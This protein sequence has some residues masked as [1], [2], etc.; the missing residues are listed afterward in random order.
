MKKIS[1]I[2]LALAVSAGVF[3][4]TDSSTGSSSGINMV[5]KRGVNILPEEGEFALG[6]NATPFLAYIGGFFSNAGGGAPSTNYA[7][8]IGGGNAI[9][10]KYMIAPDAAI[11]ANFQLNT[12]SSSLLFNVPTSNLTPNPLQPA[13][14]QDKLVTHS[15]GILLGIGYEKHRGKGRVNGYYGGQVLFGK[16]GFSSE[17]TYGN[18]I[19]ANFNTPQ[20]HNAYVS[21]NQRILKDE[22]SNGLTFGLRP[23]VGIEYFFAAKISIGGEFGYSL[24]FNRNVSSVQTLEYWNSATGSVQE[25]T[26]KSTLPGSKN[27][28][29]NVDNLFG[30]INLMFYF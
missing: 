30:S 2:I 11:R 23:Y 13:Y 22:T 12:T 10:M 28:S 20:I 1:S 5:S 6:V 29:A 15:H 16:T 25:I 27:Y 21:D 26:T 19:N 8:N 9:Y 14:S 18:P 3:A 7:T 4:Q 24:L 17:Y